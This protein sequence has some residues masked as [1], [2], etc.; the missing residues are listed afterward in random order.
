M[1]FYSSCRYHVI[2]SK[3][4]CFWLGFASDLILWLIVWHSMYSEESSFLLGF[5]VVFLFLLL[6]PCNDLSKCQYN[7]LDCEYFKE[8]NFALSFSVRYYVSNMY[9][10]FELKEINRF[11]FNAP[12]T[13]NLMPILMLTLLSLL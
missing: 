6:V 9:F 10:T 12:I 2:G 13:I 3:Y 4:S 1:Q 11:N 7:F 8:R 5:G